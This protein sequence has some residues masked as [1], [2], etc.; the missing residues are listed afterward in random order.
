MLHRPLTSVRARLISGSAGAL[1]AAGLLA[2]CVDPRPAEPLPPPPMAEAE[3]ELYGAPEDPIGDAYAE[4]EPMP[5]PMVEGDPSAAPGFDPAGQA[6]FAQRPGWGTMEPVPNPPGSPAAQGRAFARAEPVQPRTD[7][8]PSERDRVGAY[9]VPPPDVYAERYAQV[10]PAP[11]PAPQ[12]YAQARPAPAPQPY[13]EPAP[14][15]PVEAPFAEG[16]PAS[17]YPSTVVTM[18]P[19][20]NPVEVARVTP[21]VR[22]VVQPRAERQPQRPAD[23]RRTERRAR[24]ADERLLGGPARPERRSAAAAEAGASSRNAAATVRS[25]GRSTAPATTAAAPARPSGARP[26][27]PRATQSRP[28]R[29]ARPAVNTPAGRQAALDRLRNALTVLVERDSTL[30]LDPASPGEQQR[31]TLTLPAGLAEALTREAADGGLRSLASRAEV[32]A[33]LQGDDWRIEPE[34]PQNAPIEAGQVPAFTWKATPGPKAGP[35][36]ADIS[37]NLSGGGRFETLDLGEVR[38]DVE[39]PAAAR[40]EGG[41]SA[42][43]LAAGALILLLLGGAFWY[44]R[45]DNGGSSLDGSRR[46]FNRRRPDPVNL[47]PYSPAADTDAPRGS[48]PARDPN[49]A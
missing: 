35:L 11:A 43:V 45:R 49:P 47:T 28:E 20:P 31:V 7:G 21:R 6:Q 12:P 10:R 42:R 36:T 46:R 44:A 5:E 18:P 37:A 19:V 23:P 3:P 15:P 2:A 26:D 1:V 27:T 34:E 39:G 48:D 30:A 29:P 22:A 38:R 4:A 33:M 17:S 14:T 32:R 9:E 16:L 13:V 41:V 24:A 25:E 40:R 8:R